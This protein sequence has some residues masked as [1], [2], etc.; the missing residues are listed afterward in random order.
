MRMHYCILKG[1]GKDTWSKRQVIEQTYDVCKLRCKS[2]QQPGRDGIK[3]IRL[4]WWAADREEAEGYVFTGCND[5][6]LEVALP[7]K[8]Q[9]FEVF[10]CMMYLRDGAWNKCWLWLKS[11]SLQLNS[12]RFIKKCCG[13]FTQRF[14][15]HK[16]L[17]EEDPAKIAYGTSQWWIYW[18]TLRTHKL[19]TS[20]IVVWLFMV[21][22]WDF[23]AAICNNQNV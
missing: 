22:A 9:L 11:C 2:L 5:N 6:N 15:I 7:V 14:Q 10:P 1:G 4:C 17:H 12:A 21:R 23:N 18:F 20:K 13:R 19:R 16:R 3:Q 8:P